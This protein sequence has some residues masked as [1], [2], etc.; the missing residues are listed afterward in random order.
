MS[1]LSGHLSGLWSSCALEKGGQGQHPW[2]LL[3]G[4]LQ[5]LQQSTRSLPGV[6]KR[7]PLSQHTDAILEGRKLHIPR[8][9]PYALLLNP[10][11]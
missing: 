1:V 6:L 5:P 4:I 8:P 10:Q 3:K 2:A 11:R 7:P 9:R